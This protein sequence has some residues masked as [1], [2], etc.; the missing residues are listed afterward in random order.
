METK[1]EYLRAKALEYKQIK[2]ANKLALKLENKI[3]DIRAMGYNLIVLGPKV[4]ITI[5]K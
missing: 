2:K 5:P 3:A 4:K 1:K